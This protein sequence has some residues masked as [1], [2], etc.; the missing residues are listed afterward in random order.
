MQK[1]VGIAGFGIVGKS[2]L[3]FFLN[4]S[5]AIS[6]TILSV[7][8]WREL[9]PEEQALFDQAGAYFVSGDLEQLFSDN[10]MVIPSPGI[11]LRPYTKFHEKIVC[12]LD[13]FSENFLKKTVAITGTLGKT[14]ITHMLNDV[15][16]GRTAIAGNVGH[17][18]LDL[19][20]KQDA[21]DVA[22]LELSSFQ[23]DHSKIFAPDVA[24]LTN[25]YPN[26][27][28]RH[29]TVEAYFDAKWRLFANQTDGQ[30]ALF[31]SGLFF[32][33]QRELFQDNLSCYRGDYSVVC[34]DPVPESL[35]QNRFL[36]DKTI[37]FFDQWACG[38]CCKAQVINA[39]LVNKIELC[40][41]SRHI[42][43]GFA[44]NWLFVVGALDLLG[45]GF[46]R[47]LGV[48]GVVNHRLELF[49]TINGIDFYNDSKATVLQATEAAVSRLVA[50]GRSM[51]VIV[52]GLGKGVDRTGLVRFLEQESL[53]KKVF[54]LG[55]GCQEFGCYES[56]TSLDDLVRA[57]MQT[58]LP[59]DQV[60]FS[61]SGASFDLFKSFEDRGN[62]FK[63]AVEKWG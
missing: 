55:A 9:N 16:P 45:A 39:Q 29:L 11:D 48:C 5:N 6:N 34:N 18:M 58:A 4:Q 26:H 38:V 53:V 22:I 35:L 60:L 62:L 37:Y 14:T 46:P 40:D 24:I 52:G 36:Q 61:P 2:V 23:T 30:K 41:L 21:L 31:S 51:I 20:A 7:W 10:D 28:D 8:D 42:K 17:P 43:N 50:N 13:L 57:I 27:L 15:L 59:G 1:R 33:E 32:S 56:Y 3:R 25:F 44:Q 19:I 49:T 63:D 47:G 12:E 54:Y